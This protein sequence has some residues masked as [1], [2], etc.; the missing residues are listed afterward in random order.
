M[1]TNEIELIVG[2]VSVVICLIFAIWGN[3]YYYEKQSKMIEKEIAD[4]ERRQSRAFSLPDS[5]MGI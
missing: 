4:S 2:A 1:I 3:T 5:D